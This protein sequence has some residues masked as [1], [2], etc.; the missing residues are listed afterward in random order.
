MRAIVPRI[1]ADILTARIIWIITKKATRTVVAPGLC[2]TPEPI[3]PPPVLSPAAYIQAAFG[4]DITRAA[5]ELA[6]PTIPLIAMVPSPD[7]PPVTL[8]LLF[9][10][11]RDTTISY[12][13]AGR[14]FLSHPAIEYGAARFQGG[15]TWDSDINQGLFGSFL[16]GG[17]H[18]SSVWRVRRAQGDHSGRL[19]LTL[20]PV[21]PAA[22]LPEPDFS[23]ISDDIIRAETQKSWDD[24]VHALS[25]DRV[26][27][28][29]TSAKQ[30]AEKL[31][32][33][34]LL[35]V[36]RITSGNYELY[37][38]L[39]RLRAMLDD[40]QKRHDLPFTDLDY[41]IMQKLRILHGGTHIGRIVVNRRAIST[42]YGMSVVSDL[43]ELLTSFGAVQ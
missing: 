8:G 34:G 40:R 42:E 26:D 12:E 16:V 41:H 21:K 5:A 22:G 17:L 11:V 24:L 37:E 9:N 2:G 25:G 7:G 28:V 35:K 38:L 43:I 29:V 18:Q 30:I 10:R 33:Y 14:S 3:E 27:V 15:Y 32:Y 6:D 20:Q 31:L 1:M 23:I 4:H 36:G 39:S 13:V 19:L